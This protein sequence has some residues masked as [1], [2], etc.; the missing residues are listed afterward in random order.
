MTPAEFKK[1]WAKYTG[2][3]S[4]A[5]QEH[6]NDLC[7]LL[8]EPT[9]AEADSSGE[10]F[11]C[12]QKHVVKDAELFDA[13][14]PD[15]S[16]PHE[17]GF[18]DVWKK[19]C[20]AWEYKGKKKNLDEAYKQLLRYRE[21]LLN[22]P[23]LVVCDFDRYVIRT[24]F[25]GTVQET[26]EF[27]NDQIDRPENF[28]TLRALFG[29]PDFLKPQRTTAQ[30]TEKLAATIAEVAKSLQKRESV[31]LAD[32]KTRAEV[33]FAQRRNLRIARFLNRIV[34]CFFAEDS[35]LLP[36]NLFSDI[37][38]TALADPK[39]FAATLE[40]LFRVM[41]DGGNFGQHKIRHFNGH[42]FEE[43]TVFELNDHELGK[44]IEAAEADWQYIEP[45]I[46]GTLFE[47]ALEP[48]QRSQLG[49]HYTSE[50][51][52]RTLVEPVLMAPLRRQW[53]T[54]KGELAAAFK[55]G[56]AM[57]AE[58][59]QSRAQRG[60]RIPGYAVQGVRGTGLAGMRCDCR[61]SA[62]S[63]RETDSS[64]IRRCLR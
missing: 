58:E 22:P 48:G 12:F 19:G 49:A 38:K 43:A 54:M 41:A 45:S 37:A 1:K 55:K 3:E 40:E 44:L 35:G 50:A 63:R 47:R 21:S 56:K 51:D 6:F 13:D 59:P 15:S 16:D 53:A 7:R 52:I 29:E 26:H 24:N 60:T 10:D 62:V 4:S 14:A 20:F 31:E 61:Q 2:K 11:F 5:Y 27:T 36:K 23:L 33:N 9:P 25:N 17:R 46:M 57:K 39:H 8:Q 34:F 42:L 30:V 28:R 18:A 32:A 64:R